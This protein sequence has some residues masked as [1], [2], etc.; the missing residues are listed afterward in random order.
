MNARLFSPVRLRGVEIP[1]RIVVSPMCQYSAEDGMPNDWH[2]VHLGSRAV[3]GAGMVIVEATAVSPQGRISPGDLGLWNDL[4]A[5]A[6]ERS[7]RFIAEQGSIP[8]IQL[9]HAGRKAATAPPWANQGAPLPENETWTIVAPSA[10]PFTPRHQTPKPLERTE[11]EEITVAFRD[12]AQRGVSAG[13]RLLELHMAHGYLLHQFLS[14]LSNMRTDEF[15]GSFENRIRFPLQIVSAI[16]SVVPDSFPVV[17]RISATDWAPGGWEIEQSVE[18]ARALGSAGVDAIDCSS[19][20][21]V[22]TATIP[23]GPGYQV[24]FASRI[25]KETGLPTAAVGFIT[26]PEQAEQIVRTEQADMVILAREFLRDPYWPLHAATRLKQ[27][28][29]WPKQYMRAKS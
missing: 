21:N 26:S 7:T 17:A 14:P 2:L 27:E 5:S 29:P 11:I 1:N 6:L 16:R 20:G 4:Q 19:G 18:F 3:G 9:S 22:A 10:I 28:I 15:G 24:P 25:K 13:F 12:A 8:A 23:V